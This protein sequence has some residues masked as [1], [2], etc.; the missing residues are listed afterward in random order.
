MI[1]FDNVTKENMKKNTIHITKNFIHLYRMLIVGSSGSKKTNSLFNLISQQTD[2]NKNI[3]YAKN[4]Y[5]AKYQFSSNTPES[6][7]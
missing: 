4:L 5:E 2:I 6:A 7:A 1:T 3:L